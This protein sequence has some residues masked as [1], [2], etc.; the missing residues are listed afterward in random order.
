[1]VIVLQL[2]ANNQVKKQGFFF[3]K[4]DQPG[5]FYWVLVFLG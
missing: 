5:G 3:E 4:K 1:M 2:L